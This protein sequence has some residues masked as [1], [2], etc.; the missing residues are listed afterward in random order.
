MLLLEAAVACRTSVLFEPEAALNCIVRSTFLLQSM[1]GLT[2]MLL[3]GRA[4]TVTAEAQIAATS[5]ARLLN[6]NDLNHFSVACPAVAMLRGVPGRIHRRKAPALPR[7]A[8]QRYRECSC[9]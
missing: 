4:K 2:V 1:H 3:A 5:G 6:H 8:L 9:Q 7:T